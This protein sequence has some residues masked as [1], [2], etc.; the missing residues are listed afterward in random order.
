VREEPPGVG[1]VSRTNSIFI[2]STERA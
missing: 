1:T 2:L